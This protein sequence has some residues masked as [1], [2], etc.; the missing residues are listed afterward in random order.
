MIRLPSFGPRGEG[1]VAIQAVLL[2]AVVATMTLGPAWT[3]ALRAV[4]ATAGLLLVLAG[5]WLAVRGARDLADNL[6]PFPRPN[7]TNRLVKTGSYGLVR[8]PI[9]GGLILAAA[10][11]GLL[12]ASPATLLAAAAL[13]LLFEL[14]SRR[15]EDW[16]VERHPGYA[17]YRARTRRFIPGLH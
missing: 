11:L 16:L 1:Y 15:E 10:G 4:G 8:H 14:K 5:G 2:V 7:E 13:D 12:A 9:Y 6:T 17:A 3:G